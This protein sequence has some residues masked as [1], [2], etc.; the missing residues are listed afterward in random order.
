MA[1]WA[2]HH[3]RTPPDA[4]GSSW[5][6]LVVVSTHRAH[7]HDTR[8]RGYVQYARTAQGAAAAMQTSGT[9]PVHTRVPGKGPKPSPT[10]PDSA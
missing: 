2:R 1:L 7:S 8:R 4:P 5:A 3:M 9:S 10:D 6:T